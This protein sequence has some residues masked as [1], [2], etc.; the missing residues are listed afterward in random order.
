M[1]GTTS[2]VSGWPKAHTLP[3][4]KWAALRVVDTGIGICEEDL[5]HIFERFYRVDAE[6]SVPGAG[7]GLS[8]AKELVNLHAGYLTVS[9]EPDQG[10]VFCVYLPLVM[11]NQYHEYLREFDERT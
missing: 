3:G 2:P 10:S 6:G 4:G 9:S 1:N 8:I 5:P 7:L 11:E